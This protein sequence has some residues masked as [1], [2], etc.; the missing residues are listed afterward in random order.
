MIDPAELAPSADKP[1]PKT[2]AFLKSTLEKEGFVVET[3][4]DITDPIEPLSQPSQTDSPD[5][6]ETQPS[7]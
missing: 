5:H 2:V 1:D 7:A 6:P 4:S 3:S